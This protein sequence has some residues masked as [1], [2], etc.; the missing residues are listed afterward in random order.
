[1]QLFGYSMAFISTSLGFILKYY[2]D[3][4]LKFICIIIAIFLGIE[5]LMYVTII[6]ILISI[7]KY[8]NKKAMKQ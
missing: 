8:K 6:F 3:F 7:S 2:Y 5:T 1:M 4:N